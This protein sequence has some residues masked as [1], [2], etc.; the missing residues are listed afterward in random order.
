MLPKNRANVPS[1]LEVVISGLTIHQ[2]TP[3]VVK[4]PLELETRQE[5][6]R[7]QRHP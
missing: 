5:P 1:S 2:K 3:I 6:K 4:A 7:K